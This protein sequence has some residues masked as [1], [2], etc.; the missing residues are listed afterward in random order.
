[1][2]TVRALSLG[3]EDWSVGRLL[4]HMRIETVIPAKDHT[5]LDLLKRQEERKEGMKE[6]RQ[7]KIPPKLNYLFGLPISGKD[8]IIHVLA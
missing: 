1:M 3:A 7:K 6:E 2:T 8:M 4:A 5:P